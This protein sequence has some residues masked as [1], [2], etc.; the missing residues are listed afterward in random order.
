[1]RHNPSSINNS[2][3]FKLH[4]STSEG[5]FSIPQKQT[6]Y[7][8]SGLQARIFP[9]DFTFGNATLVYS[10]AEVA[11]YGIFDGVP[12]L[13][14]W[15]PTGGSAEFYLKGAKSGSVLSCQGCS[16]VGFYSA[17]D[18]VI[19]TFAQSAGMSVLQFDSGV[20]AL[21]LD[22]SAAYGFWVPALTKD[23]MV[24]VEDTGEFPTLLECSGSANDRKVFVS[25]PYLVRS[26]SV[27][28]NTLELTGDSNSTT[29]LDVFACASVKSVTWNGKSTQLSKT[30]YG[31]LKGKLSG[32]TFNIS[33]PSLGPWKVQDSLPERFA[34]Y[35]D[36]G[37]AWVLANHN[38]TVN[39]YT[40]ATKPYLY[41]D[42]YGFHTGNHLWRGYFNGGNV[43][44]V[45]LSVQG[46]DAF[47]WSAYLNGVFLGSWLGSTND[48]NANL[49]LS[50]SNATLNPHGSNVLLII[51]DNTGH[52]ETTSTTV[53]RGILDA[54]LL[55][56]GNA[57]FT[58]WKVAGTA[59]GSNSTLLDTQ[60][61]IYNEGGLYG[62]RLGWH[63]PG[64]D[65]SAWPTSSPSTGFSGA[66]VNFYRTKFPLDIPSGYDVS[67]SAILSAPGIKTFRALL[68][69][70][71]WQ[72]AR[73]MP[74]LDTQVNFPVPAGVLDYSGE[75][76]VAVAVWAQ[77]EGGA[78]LDVEFEV[79]YVTESSLD[80]R[81]D[82]TY[83]RPAW[84]A[85]R[86]AYA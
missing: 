12:T 57:A 70:N 22:R 36:S 47:G 15:V 74:Y 19:T 42:E 31:S 65:D 8:L 2:E 39:P 59:G 40:T 81:F 54:T 86:L 46:G 35:S 79:Q 17:A 58:Q 53:P 13:V 6:C 28:G 69:V 30:S 55:G 75:D 63:L 61:T 7:T 4:V 5:N 25:G 48:E 51:Q 33:I 27:S 29:D 71:G 72:L 1:L 16:S 64:F 73:F 20:K 80:L 32:P 76:T 10:T 14:L 77:E 85:K 34:N 37:P 21:L 24:A 23:P 26:A 9:T 66:T 45:Y 62:E 84:D 78:Q 56:S 67:I 44:G 83:L 82:G 52:D 50:F 18:G 43:T 68:Y 41:V 11:T 3:T 38:T 60:R 49:T